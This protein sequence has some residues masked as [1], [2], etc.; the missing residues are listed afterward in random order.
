MS[1][2]IGS[3]RIVDL[4]FALV[5][6][7]A[8]LLYAFWRRTGRGVEPL[9]VIAN[10]AAGAALLAALRSVLVGADPSWTA[11]WLAAAA[12]AH[13]ADITYRWR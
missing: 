8:I 3:G 7:E 2:L 11:T 1:D 13:V 10:L 12:V 5:F 6:I 9:A 4:I